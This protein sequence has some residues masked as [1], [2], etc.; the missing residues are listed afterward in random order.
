MSLFLGHRAS[1]VTRLY[2]EWEKES[3]FCTEQNRLRV[4]LNVW[5]SAQKDTGKRTES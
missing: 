4:L 1:P 2:K 5:W 3:L